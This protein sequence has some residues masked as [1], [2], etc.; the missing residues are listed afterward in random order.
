MNHLGDLKSA[1]QGGGGI[2]V[3]KAKQIKH[4]TQH[5]QTKRY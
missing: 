3:L 5:K 4:L 2:A 1:N